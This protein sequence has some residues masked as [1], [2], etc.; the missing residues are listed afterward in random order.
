MAEKLGIKVTP[1][2]EHFFDLAESGNFAEMKTLFDSLTTKRDPKSYPV[3]LLAPLKETFGVAEVTHDWPAQKLLDYGETILNSLRPGMVYFGGTDPGRFIPTL[4]NETGTGD[5]HIILTQNAFADSS[6]LDYVRYLYGDQ[7]STLD[8]DDSQNGFTAYMEDGRKRLQHDAD[9]PDEPKQLLPGEDLQ[10]KED[11][12]FQAS[13]QVAVMGVNERLLQAFLDKNPDLSF[14]LEE[15]FPLKSTYARAAPLGPLMELRVTDAQREFTPGA[16][17]QSLDY[18]RTTADQLLADTADGSAN[19]YVLKT[20]SKMAATQAALFADHQ[21]SAP[22]EQAFQ[23]ATQMYP[24][25]ADAVQ[26]YVN[27]LLAQQRYA[28]AIKVAQNAVNASPGNA[29]L[30]ALLQQLRQRGN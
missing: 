13:G 6:Y 29:Q 14:A 22:A 25:N 7:M 17:A 20:Y 5:P 4:L 26:P 1:Q 9:F 15:S 3:E 18:W 27:L 28:D 19:D 11:G 10:I 8:R 21:L 16:A 2:M 30:L 24:G 23:I 12:R